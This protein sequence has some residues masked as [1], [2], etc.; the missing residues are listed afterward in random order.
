[1]RIG[2]RTVTT[3]CMICGQKD[4]EVVA[5]IGRGHQPLTT[6]IC[7]GCGMVNHDPLP[8][9]ASVREFYAKRYRLAYKGAW[10]PKRKHSVRAL[11]GAAARARRL[12]AHAPP[13]ARVLDVGAS[14]GEFTYIMGR[15]GYVATGLEPNEGYAAFARRTYGVDIVNAPLEE[16]V[17]ARGAF[18]LIT[19]NHVFEHLVDPLSALKQLDQWLAEDGLL[20]IEVPNLQGVRKQVSNT[21]HYAHIWNFTPFTLKAVLSKAGFVPLPD[22]DLNTTS[23]VFARNRTQS[24]NTPQAAPE[25]AQELI[26]QMR[27]KQN[28]FA[29]VQSGAPFTRRWRRLTR[30]VDE[31]LTVSRFSSVRDIAEHIL[32]HAPIAPHAR[33]DVQTMA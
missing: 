10:E 17:F 33:G 14:A 25:L 23:L 32:A 24:S 8:D 5:T 22:Q 2:D 1:M 28:F 27:E 18:D 16:T 3:D 26:K 15:S 7:L 20:F 21:F 29:Y 11:H 12:A 30:S 31:A 13:G 9:A 6:V 19:L 4:R